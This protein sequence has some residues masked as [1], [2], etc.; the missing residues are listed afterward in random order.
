MSTA[1]L[2][3][4]AVL[5]EDVRFR[6][7]PG[8]PWCL[9]IPH[10]SLGLGESLFLHG[11]SGSGKSTLLNLIGGVV[12]A[13][14]GRVH[15]LGTDFQHAGAAARDRIRADHVGFLFQQFNLV[16]YLTVVDNV[17]LPCRFS[18]RRA[19]R[20]LLQSSSPLAEALRLLARLDLAPDLLKR[21][22]TELSIGQ[23]QRVAAARAM[24]GAPEIIV[25]D[26]PTSALDAGR[27]MAFLEL[28]LEQCAQAGS[29]LLFVSHDRRLENA[30]SRTLALGEINRAHA[31]ERGA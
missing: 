12:V 29:S 17:L 3:S 13:D 31:E 16:P 30:F 20:C 24:I 7:K 28:L 11:P 27:Q 23:Q 6:W 14:Q 8:L 2:P 25:A 9:E 10:L 22:V 15:V 1:T 19:E 4:Q 21:R 5:I 26:E 18:R